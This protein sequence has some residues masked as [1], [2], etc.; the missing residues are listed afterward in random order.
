MGFEPSMNGEPRARGMKEEKRRVWEKWGLARGAE[1]GM[2]EEVLDS[3]ARGF[4]SEDEV[5]WEVERG[6]E[7][8]DRL[9]AWR[10]RRAKRLR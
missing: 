10:E 9:R 7:S 1:K 6:G 2:W 3:E 8:E 4:A 5:A